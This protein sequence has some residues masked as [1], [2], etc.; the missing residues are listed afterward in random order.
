MS[1]SNASLI[2]AIICITLGGGLFL[3][4]VYNWKYRNETTGTYDHPFTQSAGSK[5]SSY[6]HPKSKTKSK[7]KSK[8]KTC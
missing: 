3:G 1:S 2:I 6:K 4:G 7:T 8:R 5:S